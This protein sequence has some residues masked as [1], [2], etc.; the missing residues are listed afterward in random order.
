[1]TPRG[2][3]GVTNIR[4]P[5]YLSAYPWRNTLLQRVVSRRTDTKNNDNNEHF[6]CAYSVTLQSSKLWG[7]SVGF[8][9]LRVEGPMV[10]VLTDHL[11]SLC[12]LVPSGLCCGGVVP[13]SISGKVKTGG[14]SLTDCAVCHHA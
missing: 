4:D 10:G 5:L 14:D 6:F 9:T 7:G 11:V 8:N 2:C 12:K 1:M 3:L 13:S